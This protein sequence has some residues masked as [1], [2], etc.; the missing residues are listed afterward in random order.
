[1]NSFS[2]NLKNRIPLILTNFKKNR[3]VLTYTQTK[4]FLTIN[5][6]IRNN[7]N[8]IAGNLK[9]ENMNLLE[10]LSRSNYCE[11]IGNLVM[12]NS[13]NEVKITFEDKTFS[14]FFNET[15]S[16]DVVN[17]K[18]QGIN[19][20]IQAVEFIQFESKEAL[21]EEIKLK[22]LMKDF[23][24]NP[25]IIKINKHICTTYIPG[26]FP[27]IFEETEIANQLQSNNPDYLKS[28]EDVK[29]VILLSLYELKEKNSSDN[30]NYEEQK[31]LFISTVRS[32]LD[33][34]EKF[35]K[36]LFEK[37]A[38]SEK[39]VNDKLVFTSKVAVKL[40][41]LFAISHFSLF[42]ALI[43]K[44]YAWDVIEP[45]TYVVGNVYWIITL[46]FLAFNNRKLDFDI[47]QYNSIRDVYFNKY[48]KQLNYSEEEKL[49]LQEEIQAIEQ[50]RSGLADI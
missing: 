33:Q 15:D 2:R 20:K 36:S 43:Y 45:I 6:Q 8:F 42:Y 21:L 31:A 34:R 46:G 38:L 25:F 39:M 44:F 48:A 32:K 23:V 26:V 7:S 4:S 12:L 22:T 17:K 41:M 28:A 5:K 14:I 9:N 35:L 13:K 10:R 3:F 24:K 37:Q 16:I 30:K 1:M 19:D 11:K 49:K 40:G 47:L 27:L 18:I 50:L 29:N